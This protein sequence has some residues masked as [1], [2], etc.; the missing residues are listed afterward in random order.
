MVS[1]GTNFVIA[2]SLAVIV[3]AMVLTVTYGTARAYSIGGPYNPHRAAIRDP[4]SAAR[5]G[6]AVHGDGQLVSGA[7][8]RLPSR[9]GEH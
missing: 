5:A 4:E 6:S 9:R 1:K 3:L 8:H 7:G 2:V